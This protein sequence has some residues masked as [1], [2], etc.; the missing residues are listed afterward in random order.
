MVQLIYPKSNPNCKTK[1]GETALT[2]AIVNKHVDIVRA[3]LE[4]GVDVDATDS[5]EKT[6]LHLSCLTGT[7]YHCTFI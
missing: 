5:G 4:Y 6:A 3:L 1:K 7:I 2:L